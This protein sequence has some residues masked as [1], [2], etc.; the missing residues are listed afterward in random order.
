[1]HPLEDWCQSENVSDYPIG[2]DL[3]QVGVFDLGVASLAKP[4][5][6]LVRSYSERKRKKRNLFESVSAYPLTMDFEALTDVD[7]LVVSRA[8]QLGV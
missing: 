1:M 4:T 7:L 6:N 5:R 2:M 8:H 3:G